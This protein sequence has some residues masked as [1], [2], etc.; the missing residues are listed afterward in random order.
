MNKLWLCEHYETVCN[1]GN[2]GIFLAEKAYSFYLILK[3]FFDLT[4]IMNHNK[5]VTGKQRSCLGLVEIN[6]N[7]LAFSFLPSTIGKSH[8]L[9][10]KN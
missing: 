4:R 1:L 7:R 3:G 8:L 6:E 9:L 2:M 5:K 10:P